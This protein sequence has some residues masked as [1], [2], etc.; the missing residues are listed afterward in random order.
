[1]Y[2]PLQDPRLFSMSVAENITYGCTQPVSK[3]KLEEAAF[4]AN[5]LGFIASLPNGFDT[6]VT[7]K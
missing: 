4:Q 7:D 3:E 6:I 2:T 1:M 5:A